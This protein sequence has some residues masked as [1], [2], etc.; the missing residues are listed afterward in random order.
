MMTAS[1]P[2]LLPEVAHLV[3]TVFWTCESSGFLAHILNRLSSGRS[4][5]S[6]VC[7]AQT[8]YEL[9]RYYLQQLLRSSEV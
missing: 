8:L 9:E 6:C 4:L 2:K 7:T 1:I 3:S 5:N